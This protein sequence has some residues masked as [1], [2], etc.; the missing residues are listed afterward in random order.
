MASTLPSQSSNESQ[1]QVDDT[2]IITPTEEFKISA[3]ERNENIVNMRNVLLDVL[4]NLLHDS[5]FI[6]GIDTRLAILYFLI[7]V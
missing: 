1:I 6:N 5:H 2:S 7:H 3:I 4:R